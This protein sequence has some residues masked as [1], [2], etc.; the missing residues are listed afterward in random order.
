MME[1]RLH[2]DKQSGKRGVILLTLLLVELAGA[3]PNFH[4]PL[5]LELLCVSFTQVSVAV[6]NV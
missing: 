5:P 1:S 3:S 4:G 6:A 2:P